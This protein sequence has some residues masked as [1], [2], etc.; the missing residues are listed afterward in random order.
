L[1]KGFAGLNQAKPLRI[2]KNLP[3]GADAEKPAVLKNV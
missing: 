1:K 3:G 2:S